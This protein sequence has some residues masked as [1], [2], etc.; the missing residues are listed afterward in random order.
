MTNRKRK[1]KRKD[2][3][4]SKCTLKRRIK[5]ELN[6]FKRKK[7]QEKK[8]LNLEKEHFRELAK[9]DLTQKSLRILYPGTLILFEQKLR[10][11]HLLPTFKK[12]LC[13]NPHKHLKDFHNMVCD[14]MRPHEIIE[15]QLNL[16]AFPFSRIDGAQRW[17][18]YLPLRS[19]T[20]WSGL[21][22]RLL[23]NFFMLSKPITQERKLIVSNKPSESLCFNIGSI[24]RSFVEVFHIL[25]FLTNTSFNTSTLGCF[26]LIKAPLMQH[27]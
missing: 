7:S 12:T 25:K 6:K 5:K 22:K 19:I 17:L 16:R 27:W 11:I 9:L 10:L 4:R 2:F 15:E 21:K 23:E 26:S 1:N 3:L 24:A 8:L 14:R 13:E 18:Y 20:M